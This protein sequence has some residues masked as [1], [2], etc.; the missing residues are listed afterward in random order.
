MTLIFSL[1]ASV[2]SDVRGEK[3]CASAAPYG[4]SRCRWTSWSSQS[5]DCENWLI[6]PGWY[7]VKRSEPAKWSMRPRSKRR[8]PGSPQDWFAHA[9]SDLRLARLARSHKTVFREQACFHAQQACEKALK[10]VLLSMAL[11]FPLVHD[12]EALLEIAKE[13]GVRLPREVR[14]AGALSPYA[15][16]AR[17]PGY[18]EGITPAEADEAIRVAGRVV[19]WAST[20][21]RTPRKK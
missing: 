19:M 4:G 11:E 6:N 1:S 10:A 21:L 15:V 9:Q 12:I 16:E 3:A 7:I 14:E 2:R 17:Y 20:T 8:R 5:V 18:E 13:G